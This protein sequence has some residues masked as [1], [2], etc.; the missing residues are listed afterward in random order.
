MAAR[1][2]MAHPV[3]KWRDV[4]EVLLPWFDPVRE[5]ARNAR[6]ESIRQR[7][8]AARQRAERVIEEYERADAAAHVQHKRLVAEVRR[9]D[10]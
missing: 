7:S 8:V 9:D 10:Q 6:T 3:G 5:R 1:P 4:V 2:P